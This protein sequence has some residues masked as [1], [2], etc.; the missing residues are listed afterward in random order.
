M[1]NQKETLL[2]HWTKNL[3]ESPIAFTF[4]TSLSI[5]SG[6][7]YSFKLI[8]SDYLLLIFGVVSPILFTL[9]LY[10][11]LLNSNGEI[12]GQPLPKAFTKIQLNRMVMLFDCSIIILF[13]ALI[14]FNI[15]N[16]FIFRFLQ[17][18]LF[19]VLLLIML[20]GFYF[21]LNQE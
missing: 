15:L 3:V 18:L 5:T 9:C 6:V 20:K 13:A 10:D 14:H 19:P 21:A 12:L 16:F 2:L 11:L 4:N 1:E 7:I 17:T 8:Q